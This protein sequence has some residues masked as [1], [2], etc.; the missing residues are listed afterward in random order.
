M[1]KQW[2]KYGNRKVDRCR[3]SNQFL[4]EVR[5]RMESECGWLMKDIVPKIIKIH[6]FSHVSFM[7]SHYPFSKVLYTV[8]RIL[9]AEFSKQGWET[10]HFT[11]PWQFAFFTLF[12]MHLMT[13]LSNYDSSRYPGSGEGDLQIYRRDS[14][15]I[16][17]R[18]LQSLK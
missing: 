5:C 17:K 14:F 12:Y 10:F 6:N 2:L 11:V 9:Y 7:T 3:H 13:I 1:L 4:K 18:R 16:W 15:Y 8:C